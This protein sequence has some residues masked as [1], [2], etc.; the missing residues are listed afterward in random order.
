MRPSW[1]TVA[2]LMLWGM[3][4]AGRR[5][6]PGGY[7]QAT[8]SATAACQ[9]NP[10]YCA[11]V[12]GEET[13]VPL[14]IRAAQVATAGKAWKEL[15]ELAEASLKEALKECAQKADAEVNRKEFGGKSPT[16]AQCD[17]Q[18]GGTR[19]NPVTRA[20]RLGSA[21]HEL[22]IRCAEEVLGSTY[23]G[24]FRLQQRYRLNP[25]TQKL[26]LITHEAELAMLRQGAGSQ[27]AGTIVPDVVIHTG[28][29]L[30]VQAVYDF[31]FPC[32]ETNKSSWRR[33]PPNNPHGVSDQ[34]AAYHKLLGEPPSLVTPT[35]VLP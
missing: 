14:Q 4:C 29:P 11:S 8:D 31:K 1:S 20:M 9:R 30:Q 19:E 33:Y 17:E 5:G 6:T 32:P 18:V 13:V 26:E 28:D 35:R 23:P 24:R 12:A 16:R 10:A 25:Q 2:V 27:L 3:G 34:G 22:A 7:A 21:K 15:G